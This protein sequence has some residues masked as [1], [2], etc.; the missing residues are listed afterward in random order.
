MKAMAV[1]RCLLAAFAAASCESLPSVDEEGCLTPVSPATCFS[2]AWSPTAAKEPLCLRLAEHLRKAECEG[3]QQTTFKRPPQVPPLDLSL[4]NNLEEEE[5]EP[6]PPVV[7]NADE[8]SLDEEG[9]T[10]SSAPSSSSRPETDP[11]DGLCSDPQEAFQSEGASG[12]RQPASS[13]LGKGASLR[14]A[15]DMDGSSQSAPD[16]TLTPLAQEKT[17][18][19]AGEADSD[20]EQ[21]C[22]GWLLS[23][24]RCRLACQRL[25]LWA[26]YRPRLGWKAVA[27]AILSV[28]QAFLILSILSAGL[29]EQAVGVPLAL[30]VF[31]SFVVGSVLLVIG[32]SYGL[33]QICCAR[34]PSRAR[35]VKEARFQHTAALAGTLP[36]SAGLDPR[37]DT[38]EMR[39]LAQDGA[40]DH[41]RHPL[42]AELATGDS[43]SASMQG[44]YGNLNNDGPAVGVLGRRGDAWC[45][46]GK[47]KRSQTGGSGSEQE[48][49]PT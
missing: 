26:R 6:D 14:R 11:V 9:F 45:R 36:P 34:S 32:Y 20:V 29:S 49:A 47:S 41:Y 22:A 35:D 12:M 38:S 24:E 23:L 10:S 4:L 2:S 5:E 21:L 48:A 1:H 16:E 43:G 8:E 13:T 15:A 18:I 40:Y 19:A 3:R 44:T 30:R 17:P 42:D 46:K 31:M 39:L 25:M 33:T 28:V 7:Q 37:V 27:C